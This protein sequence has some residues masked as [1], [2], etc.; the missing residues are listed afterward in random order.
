MTMLTASQRYYRMHASHIIRRK[1]MK[2][3]QDTGRLPRASTI[4]AHAIDETELKVALLTY[5]KTHPDTR[6][7]RRILKQYIPNGLE[8]GAGCSKKPSQ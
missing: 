4:Q 3:V 1:T 6:A 5:A 8:S 7:S 2:K